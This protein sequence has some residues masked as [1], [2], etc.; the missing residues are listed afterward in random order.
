MV[1]FIRI[2]SGTDVARGDGSA[3]THAPSHS[4]GIRMTRPLANVVGELLVLGAFFTERVQ[5]IAEARGT[6]KKTSLGAV[7]RGNR[8]ARNKKQP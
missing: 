6:R 7:K 8:Y 2:P 4:R 1:Y 3:A 5:E